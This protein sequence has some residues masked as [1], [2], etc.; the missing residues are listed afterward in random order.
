MAKQIPDGAIADGMNAILWTTVFL[1]LAG[2]G[3]GW[4]LSG[5]RIVAVSLLAMRTTLIVSGGV[6]L[7]LAITG[8]G[9]CDSR[10][11]PSWAEDLPGAVIV[12]GFVLC[13]VSLLMPP[14]STPILAVMLRQSRP[15]RAIDVC[16]DMSTS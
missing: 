11:G 9:L 5:Y 4:F 6:I 3:V 15:S 10:C 1:A 16:S 2:C 14:I 8:S 13:A 7:R 12:L